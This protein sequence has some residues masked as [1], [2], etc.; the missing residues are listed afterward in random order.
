VLADR[1]A[2]AGLIR[3]AMQRAARAVA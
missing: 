1:G 2:G 3:M